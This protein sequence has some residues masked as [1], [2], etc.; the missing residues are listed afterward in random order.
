MNPLARLQELYT[1]IFPPNPKPPT[2]E[3]CLK[4]D[5][6]RALTEAFQARDAARAAY[7]DSLDRGD[8]RDQH[9]THERFVKATVECLRLAL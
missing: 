5:R 1:F 6:P 7:L 2:P 4:L 3:E 8:C 9:T